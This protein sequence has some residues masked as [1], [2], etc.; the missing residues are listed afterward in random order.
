MSRFIYT[1]IFWAVWS[2]A[3]AAQAL[4]GLARVDPAGSSLTDGWFGRTELVLALSQGVPFRVFTLEGPPRLVVDFSEADF[5]ALS[6]D[7]LLPEQGSVS[8]LRFGVFRPGWSRLVADLSAPMLPSDVQMEIDEDSGA[9]RFSLALHPATVEEFAAASGAPARVDW[10]PVAQTPFVAPTVPDRFTVVID[11]GHGGIDPGAERSGLVEKVLA[12][13]VALRVNAALRREG[14][15]VV[16]T[17]D[18]DVFVSLEQRTA[19]AHQAGASVFMSIHADALSDGGANGATVY[20]LSEKASDAASA[21]LA[22]RHNRSDIL[23][24]LDLTGADDEVTSVLLDLARQETDPRSAALAEE[25]IAGIGQ[26]GAPLNGKPWRKAG[27]SVLKSA[28]I[29]SVLVEIG[30]LSSA[31]DRRNIADPAWRA[32]MAQTLADAV[33]QWRDADAARA[34]LVR[35]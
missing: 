30:F 12:L 28:D 31:R 20:T 25:V 27:F 24:G 3:A 26:S 6:A 8:G 16:M 7:T 34:E 29:P 15:Q 13:D 2:V 33:L 5:S 10:G 19:I 14:I 4:T 9:A 22:A 11:P 21:Q 23:A 17:R 18:R 1:L 32:Q 35:H